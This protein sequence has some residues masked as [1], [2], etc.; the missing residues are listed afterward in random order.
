M[1]RFN[2]E[3]LITEARRLEQLEIETKQSTPIKNISANNWEDKLNEQNKI[4]NTSTR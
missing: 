4:K 1:F 3:K 2:L